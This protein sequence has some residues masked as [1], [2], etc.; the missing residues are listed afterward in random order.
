MKKF[1]YFLE[2]YS[3][4]IQQKIL[5]FSILTNMPA[6]SFYSYCITI[7][8][9]LSRLFF[10]DKLYIS[11]LDMAIITSNESGKYSF[12]LMLLGLLYIISPNIIFKDENNNDNY[13]VTVQNN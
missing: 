13:D 11:Y 8:L 1:K 10:K 2:N 5:L 12:F 3:E 6:L 9:Y 4:M 7:C